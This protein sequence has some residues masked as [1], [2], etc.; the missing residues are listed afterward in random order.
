MPLL[1]GSNPL[2]KNLTKQQLTKLVNL[3]THVQSKYFE[4]CNTTN[5]SQLLL[6][7]SLTNPDPRPVTFIGSCLPAAD[8]GQAFAISPPQPLSRCR[9]RCLASLFNWSPLIMAALLYPKK[10]NADLHVPTAIYLGI[11]YL[12]ALK[13]PLAALLPA[14]TSTVS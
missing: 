4:A 9:R 1:N 3:E 8:S 13:K 6:S 10:K 5:R 14:P 2:T 7:L 11:V 12:C